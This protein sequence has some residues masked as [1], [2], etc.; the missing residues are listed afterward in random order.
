MGKKLNG[1]VRRS[2]TKGHGCTSIVDMT[3]AWRNSCNPTASRRGPAQEDYIG[4]NPLVANGCACIAPPAEPRR[5]VQSLALFSDDCERIGSFSSFFFLLQQVSSRSI[6]LLSWPA[7]AGWLQRLASSLTQDLRQ[8]R[9]LLDS[10]YV[11]P[12]S[13]HVRGILVQMGC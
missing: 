2:Y 7:D 4:N 3:S 13:V 11:S 5:V 12:K 6:S 8:A 10:R 1:T 9:V